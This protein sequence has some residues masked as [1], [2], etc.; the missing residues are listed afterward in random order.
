[1]RSPC[2][3]LV[4]PGCSHTEQGVAHASPW[5]QF[6]APQHAPHTHTARFHHPHQLT[7]TGVAS[8]L[9]LGAARLFTT[10]TDTPVC[11]HTSLSVQQNSTSAISAPHSSRRR[12]GCPDLLS[13]CSI[14]LFN[15]SHFNRSVDKRILNNTKEQILLRLVR[16]QVRRSGEPHLHMPLTAVH[17]HPPGPMLSSQMGQRGEDP[18]EK[19]HSQLAEVTVG[20]GFCK[21]HRC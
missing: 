14:H 4:V 8:S 18:E 13:I 7:D 12:S 21:L 16:V 15:I 11:G 19:P 5:L 10:F 2:R 6:S 1:M 20:N 9:G 3:R 17:G